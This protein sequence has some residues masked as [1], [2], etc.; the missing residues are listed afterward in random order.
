MAL[1]APGSNLDGFVIGSPI[2]EGGMAVLYGATREGQKFPILM[3]V[4]RIGPGEPAATV[5]SFEVESMVMA[6]LKG[7]AVPRFVAGESGGRCVPRDGARR[8]VPLE[9]FAQERPSRP[10]RSL[11]SAQRSR[12]PSTISIRRTRFTST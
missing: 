8:R 11:G 4:P 3:K 10:R 12:P 2:H 6:A 9:V 1:I 5:I 7:P